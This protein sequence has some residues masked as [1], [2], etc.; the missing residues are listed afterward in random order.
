MPEFFQY[1][2]HPNND[3]L[4]IEWSGQTF[5]KERDMTPMI[6]LLQRGSPSKQLHIALAF[7]M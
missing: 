1:Y 7:S 2:C 6:I 4:N 3:F 5:L